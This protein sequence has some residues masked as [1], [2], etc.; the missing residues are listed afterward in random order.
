[1]AEGSTVIYSPC[2]RFIMRHTMTTEV[3]CFT[4]LSCQISLSQHSEKRSNVNKYKRPGKLTQF[5]GTTL[6]IHHD[7]RHSFHSYFK[8]L[9]NIWETV[10]VAMQ[11]TNVLR[12]GIPGVVPRNM[13]CC[14]IL[15]TSQKQQHASCRCSI[16]KAIAGFNT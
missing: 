8:R 2:G 7:I 9:C 10:T 12:G 5:R 11:R 4:G 3:H 1:M 14:N 6:K 16:F 13:G 15:S